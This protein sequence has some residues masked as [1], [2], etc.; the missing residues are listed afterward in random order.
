MVSFAFQ[1]S[2]FGA[3]NASGQVAVACVEIRECVEQAGDVGRRAVMNDVEI[4]GRDRRAREYGG[5]AT[6]D[7]E[8]DAMASE[9]LKRF[10]ELRWL[11]NHASAPRRCRRSPAGRQGAPRVTVTASSGSA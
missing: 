9:N 2:R 8:V 5:D 7:D 3:E 10:F 4:K 6:H 1:G 11:A